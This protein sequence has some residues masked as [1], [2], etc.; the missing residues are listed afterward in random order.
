[1]IAGVVGK[2]SMTQICGQTEYV[3]GARVKALNTKNRYGKVHCILYNGAETF[4]SVIVWWDDMPKPS[5]KPSAAKGL[6]VCLYCS[7]V[8]LSCAKGMPI[9]LAVISPNFS[10]RSSL[11]NTSNITRTLYCLYMSNVCVGTQPPLCR[12]S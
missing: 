6:L 8:E 10:E 5:R 4:D 3:I 11:I 12:T 2:S 1:M 7:H 9:K